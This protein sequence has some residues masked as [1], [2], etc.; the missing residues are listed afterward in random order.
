MKKEKPS[1]S[2]ETVA[3]IRAT[4]SMRPTAEQVCYDPYAKD[5]LG[6]KF[7]IITKSKF[8]TRMALRKAERTD[9]GA[10]GCVASRTRY[11]DE[12]LQICIKDGIEQLVILG[13]GYDSRAYRFNELTGNVKVFELDHPAT[14]NVKKTKI[15]K[16]FGSLPAHVNYIPIDFDKEKQDKKLFESGYD[17]NLKTLFIWEG[18]TMYLTAEAVD[19]TLSFVAKNSGKG[20]SIIFNY[21]FQ[22]VV[23]GTDKREE[24]MKIRK[25][26]QKRGEPLSFGIENGKIDEFLSKRGYSQIENVTGEYFKDTYFKGKNQSRNVCCLCGFVGALVNPINEHE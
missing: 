10:V 2:A 25:S 17:K 7:T 21:I 5:F 16:I 15:K 6:P 18:V 13:A 14:Q 1:P 12:Y 4:E 20:S 23:D 26:Y 24:A 8:L 9:P 22:S 19:E 3:A 11:I